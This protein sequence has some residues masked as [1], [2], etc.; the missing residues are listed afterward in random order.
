[1]G[2]NENVMS[3]ASNNRPIAR[4]CGATGAPPTEDHYPT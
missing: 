4:D 3:H 1:M 2:F